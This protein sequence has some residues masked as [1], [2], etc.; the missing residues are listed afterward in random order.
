MLRVYLLGPFKVEH[1]GRVLTRQ[2]WARPK[3][4]TLLKLLALQ[5]GHVVPQDRLLETLWS[6]LTPAAAAN[7][8]HVAVSRLRKLLGAGPLIRR[9]G[10]GY[11]LAPGQSVWIDAEE[12]HRLLGR[13]REWRQ[14]GI[15][16]AAA[17]AYRAA[18]VLYRGELCED[19]PYE[20]WVIR[21]REEL[22]ET[23]LLLLEELTDC[24]LHIGATFEA[25][26][27]C[28]RGLA[29]DR[30]REGLYV[31][32]MRSHAAAGHLA[33]ALQAY[34]RCRRAL[35]DALGVDPGPAARAVHGQLL[36]DDELGAAT[37]SV[38]PLALNASRRGTPSLAETDL[39]RRQLPCVGRERELS[40]LAARL[41]DAEAGRG[42]LVL[43]HGEPGI[44]KSRLLQE[45]GQLAETRGARS[46]SARCYELER[47]LPYAPIADALGS[48]LAER[49]D[50]T[51]VSS[52]L[53]QWGP[54]LG[55]VIP[56]LHDLVADL[57]RYQPL[58]PDAERAAILAGLG[59]LVASLS[60]RQALVLLLDDLQSA[61][62]STIQWLHYLSRRLS[63]LSVVIVGTYRS[64]EVGPDHPLKVLVEGLGSDPTTAASL[65]ELTCLGADD[66]AALLPALTELAARLHHETDGHPLFLVETLRTLV[67]TGVLRVDERGVCLEEGTTLR[68]FERRLP[69][70]RNVSE[71]IRWRISRLNDRERRVLMAAA[72]ASRGFRSD[73]LGIM[74]NSIRRPS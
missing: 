61:D 6:D 37:L 22:R 70:P 27:L 1:K 2:E 12:F 59:H 23:Y 69:L 62:A 65:I 56:I 55:A 41:N 9:E 40:E 67:E 58:R 50:S 47:D 63:G 39:K 51:E 66:A 68:A 48:F 74:T 19:D 15:W 53:G 60:R 32:L 25:I 31:Q 13:G 57:P 72:V 33:E 21:P 10:A 54:Q 24:L 4:R 35:A 71:A 43:L 11:M 42:H 28:E 20:E 52:A 73:L 49:A 46:V 16:A 64:A 14:R 3:D 26:E 34:E 8:L 17:Q 30:T 44:G 7:S 29:R 18:A 36:R 38:G 5:P 45:F